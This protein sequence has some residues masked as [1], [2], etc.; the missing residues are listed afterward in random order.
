MNLS[1]IDWTILIVAVV[2]LRAVSLS[3][4]HY[5]KGVAD[6][7][8]ANRLAGRYL[9]TIASQMGNTGAITFIAIFEMTYKVGLA[10]GFWNGMMI[11]VSVIIL[12]TGWVFYRF[13]E[14][15]AL[16]MAQFFEMRYNRK[17]RIFAGSLCWTSGVINFGIFPAVAAHFFIYYCGIPETYHLFSLPWAFS[18]FATVMIIDL[19][20]ALTFV[21]MGGQISVMVTE[22]V[23]G[24]VSLVAFCIVIVAVL[25]QVSWPQMVHAMTLNI[26]VDKS[27]INPFHTTGVD[28]FNFWYQAIALIGAFY[29]YMAWQG[30]QGFFSSAKTPHEGKMGGIIGL[31]RQMP[32]ALCITLLALA[33]IA[34]MKL[35]EFTDKAQWVNAHLANISNESV[36]N[37]MRVPLAAVTILPVGVKG[38]LAMIFLF[39]SFTCHDTYMHSWGSIFVQDVYLPIRNKEISPED[40]IKVLRRSIFFVAAFAFL[41]SLLY[42]PT[43]AIYFFF[44]ITG[45][46][47][48]GGS[49]AVIIGGLYWKKGT[50][51][52]AFAGLISGAIIGVI[53]LVIPKVWA[54]FP[55]NGQWLYFIAM[56][57]SAL[58]YVVVSLMTCKKDY[59][60]QELLHRGKYTIASDDV[61]SDTKVSAWQKVVGIT[62]EFSKSD[63]VLALALI[64]WN[65][66]NF[67]WFVV[68]SII[69]L[70]TA[71]TGGISNYW[72]AWSHYV[73][74]FISFVLAIPITIWFTIGGIIDI[75]ALLQHLNTAT[76]DASDDG[77]VRKRIGL[78][79]PEKLEE[80]VEVS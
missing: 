13:R 72:W 19:G 6:F 66:I 33:A 62:D 20:L 45:T 14:T 80:V 39:F 74:M 42:R 18:S 75:K 25:A 2:A 5:M 67:L 65:A 16:T 7:L 36:R 64:G 32:Q 12:L 26:P 61:F 49:G 60:L 21:T 1:W 76:R 56:C 37:E 35:P 55:I 54:H 27:M 59:N 63:R 31:W 70:S 29:G 50:T 41:F 47:W 24:M 34:I 43:E 58:L 3:T 23:Q 38:L 17:F 79:E 10:P 46:L 57:S 11:P 22:C 48:L 44:A 78:D 15:R 28:D 30:G 52:G 51:Q 4:K 73:P 77:T 69:N 68:F 40:H 9:L 53:G 71:K 8:S